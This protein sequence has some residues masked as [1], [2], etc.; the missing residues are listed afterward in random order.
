MKWLLH[1][2]WD[3]RGVPCG[4]VQRRSDD[5]GNRKQ[6]GLICSRLYPIYIWYLWSWS[7]LPF[8]VPMAARFCRDIPCHQMQFLQLFLRK[9]PAIVKHRHI[10]T[11]RKFILWTQI[12]RS[13]IA[14][15]YP[16]GAVFCNV[17]AFAKFSPLQWIPRAFI[18][19]P[20]WF[21]NG[22]LQLLTRPIHEWFIQWY[23]VRVHILIIPNCRVASCVM[24]LTVRDTVWTNGTVGLWAG[25]FCQLSINHPTVPLA[26]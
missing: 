12:C 10:I 22:I 3:F 26:C 17:S 5:D 25:D 20:A 24:R 16:R 13:V 4:F 21:P 2:T 19:R 6:Q 23:A 18:P 8:L 7:N 1:F 11:S 14:D 9:L 15:P